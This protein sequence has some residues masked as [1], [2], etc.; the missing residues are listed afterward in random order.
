MGRWKNRGGKS[1][2]SLS[3]ENQVQAAAR[4]QDFLLAVSREVEDVQ[5]KMMQCR[6]EC[7]KE[8]RDRVRALGESLALG[9]NGET[10]S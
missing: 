8:L 2:Q 9:G 10:Q 5:Q 3:T 6:A 1:S 7:G 4:S